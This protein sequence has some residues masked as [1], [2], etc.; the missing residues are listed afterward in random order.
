MHAKSFDVVIVGAGAAGLMCAATAG[1]RGRRVLVLDHSDKLA[2]KIRI[3]GGGRCNFTN[4]NIH[5]E[6]YLSANPHF[7]RSA[8]AQYSQWDFIKLVERHG[9]AYHEKTLGQLFCD[10][11]AQHIIDL[12]DAECADGGVRRQLGCTIH[13][14]SRSDEGRFVL[15]TSHGEFD[16]ESLVVATGGLSIPAI[17]ATPWGYRL[18]EQFGLAITPLKPGLVP[19]TFDAA[20]QHAFGP[21]AGLSLEIAAE[22]GKASFREQALFTHK[23]VSGPA[24]LQISS[25]WQPGQLIQLDL[26]PGGNARDVLDSEAHSEQKLS[27]VLAQAWP[28]RFA[29]QWLAAQGVADAPM[30]QL[31]PKTLAALAEQIHAWPIRPGGTQGYKKAEVT[32]G[33]VDTRE[34]SSKTL[35]ANKV[36]GLFF[37]GE[38]VDV[39]GWLGGY[40]F[41]WAWSSGYVVGGRC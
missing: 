18:A 38:V 4:R 27:N 16:A 23:G 35:M 36:P 8:L 39:T 15:A 31:S 1:Q 37:V 20:E 34:L 26:L 7:V 41:Q 9:I 32:V 17:G 13:N 30:R 10:D 28:K 22:L 40:N 21:L 3:S 2:E 11:S 14:V 19:L 33:G 6:R 24:I 12:L 5:P 29:V 25:Y